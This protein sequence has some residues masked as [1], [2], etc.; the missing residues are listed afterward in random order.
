M[1]ETHKKDLP[2]WFDLR[3]Y[4]FCKSF[5][6]ID[7]AI[8]LKKRRFILELI[9]VG[10]IDGATRFAEKVW[11]DPTDCFRFEWESPDSAIRSLTFA[12]LAHKG[13]TALLMAS[14]TPQEA[15]NWGSTLEGITSGSWVTALSNSQP[16][17][18]CSASSHALL[19]N[20]NAT[21]SVLV[22]AFSAWLKDARLHGNGASKRERPAYRSW[23]SYGLLPYLDLFIWSKLTG[24]KISHDAMSKAV[25][26]KKGGDSFRN[27]VPGLRKN[28]AQ[29]ID[30]LEALSAI[31]DD[32][33]KLAP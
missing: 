15:D 24:E 2:K 27:T 22:E 6:A 33:E 16:I 5:I 19:V 8:A 7:W 4:R 18:S 26:Y 29:L 9:D 28:L 12:D 10:D 23:V 30:E 17:D 25:G 11:E 32:L 3:E 20:L 13:G 1:A 14:V 31:E 21:D